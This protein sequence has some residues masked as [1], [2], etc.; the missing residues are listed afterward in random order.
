MRERIDIVPVDDV[1]QVI[2]AALV[3]EP[4]VISDERLELPLP[5]AQPLRPP[6]YKG[7]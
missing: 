3:C 6:A 5:A 1:A 2:R 4:P 7:V